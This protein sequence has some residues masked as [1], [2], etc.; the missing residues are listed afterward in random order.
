M[1][2]L[3]ITFLRVF[4]LAVLRSQLLVLWLTRFS[5]N[6]GLYENPP[7]FVKEHSTGWVWYAATLRGRA[8]GSP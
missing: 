1:I 5:F 6:F 7:R 8:D 2:S 3:F 4:Q